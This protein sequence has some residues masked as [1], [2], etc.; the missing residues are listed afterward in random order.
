MENVN[1]PPRYASAARRMGRGNR[2]FA[3][4]PAQMVRE[5]PD[6]STDTPLALI[7]PAHFLISLATKLLR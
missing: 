2:G 1:G 6:Q 4:A 7:G 5:H 3:A